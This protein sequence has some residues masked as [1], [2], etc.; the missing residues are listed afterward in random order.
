MINYFK[1]YWDSV[2]D[3]FNNISIFLPLL[4]QIITVMIVASI[5][6]L[7][8]VAIMISK[9]GE[10]FIALMSGNTADALSKAIFYEPFNLFIM[11]IIA[12]LTFLAVIL[13]SVFFQSG[14]LGMAN[15]IV[16][17]GKTSL[18]NFK[19]YFKNTKKL[20]GFNIYKIVIIFLLSVPLMIFLL[21]FFLTKGNMVASWSFGVLA[22]ISA[23]FFIISVIWFLF[24][25]MFT[26]QVITRKKS[27]TAWE[28][29]NKSRSW[30]KK[31]TRHVIL[32]ALTAIFVYLVI[33]ITFSIT[34][35]LLPNNVWVSIVQ[36]IVY[37]IYGLSTIIF[38]FKEYKV[39][40]EKVTVKY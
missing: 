1:N 38:L 22:V 24:A 36:S 25:I 10:P 7:S 8:W 35:Q 32:T 6:S 39:I 15:E 11:G 40:D 33:S 30:L 31:K 2:K 34:D 18:R 27:K 28:C 3:S 4:I 20:F 5:G 29:M 19:K 14:I 21:L 26:E 12:L 13:V 17:K 16:E 9:Y 37:L 23:L